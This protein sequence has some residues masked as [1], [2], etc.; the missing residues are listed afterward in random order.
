MDF[1]GRVVESEEAARNNRHWVFLVVDTGDVQVGVDV[2]SE[3]LVSNLSTAT[4]IVNVTS[5]YADHGA[6]DGLTRGSP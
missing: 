2:V 1:A 3:V 5:E 4:S 6:G